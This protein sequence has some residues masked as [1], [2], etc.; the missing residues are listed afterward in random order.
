MSFFVTVFKYLLRHTKHKNTIHT[1]CHISTYVPN[2]HIYG[3]EI[4]ILFLSSDVSYCLY[5]FNLEED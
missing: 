5:Q 4:V 3:I 2:C 1:I